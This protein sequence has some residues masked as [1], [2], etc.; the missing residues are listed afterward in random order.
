[1]LLRLGY[2]DA[3]VDI[4]APVSS[5]KV[6]P[7]KPYLEDGF[8]SRSIRPNAAFICLMGHLVSLPSNSGNEGVELAN[9]PFLRVALRQQQG[10]QRVDFVVEIAEMGAAAG[11]AMKLAREH[12]IKY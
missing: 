4:R 8:A 11:K 6:L 5:P 2:L 7:S 10:Y 3:D 9:E 12:P 1:M